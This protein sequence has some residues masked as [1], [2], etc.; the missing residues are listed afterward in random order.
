VHD[1]Q[2]TQMLLDAI[3]RSGASRSSVT[4]DLL[5]SHVRH[6][7]L[8]DFTVDH[9]GDSTLHTVGIYRIAD[10]RLRFETAITPDMQLIAA[11]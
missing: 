3:A 6:G 11:G 7:L 4:E 5:H 2:A 9:N 1:A 8:G 10:G